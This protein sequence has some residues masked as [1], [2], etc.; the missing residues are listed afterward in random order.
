M[1]NNTEHTQTV[2]EA[3]QQ[4]LESQQL[5]AF[6]KQ[7]SDLV[8]ASISKKF[9]A[10]FTKQDGKII[11]IRVRGG[12]P[13]FTEPETHPSTWQAGRKKQVAPVVVEENEG[14]G[15]PTGVFM[16]ASSVSRL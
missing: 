13:Y 10:T 5:V 2:D 3:W 11:Q 4:Y 7:Q 15:D 9:G 6:A 16:V 8:L 1:E 14:T 12:V